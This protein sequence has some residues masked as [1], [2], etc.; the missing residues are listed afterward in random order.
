[1][2]HLRNIYKKSILISL[3]I[4]LIVMS[5]DVYAVEYNDRIF[6]KK[7]LRSKRL[8]AFS[9]WLEM[10]DRYK[11]ELRKE[12]KSFKCIV[13]KGNSDDIA[14]VSIENA[15]SDSED[16]R[17]ILKVTN[18]SQIDSKHNDHYVCNKSLWMK[19]K[20]LPKNSTILDKL[21]LINKIVNEEKYIIDPINWNMAD[22]W[23]TPNQFS[24]KDGDCEDYAISKYM[25]LKNIGFPKESMRVVILNDENLEI[26]H[27]VLAVYTEDGKIYILDNQISSVL[28]DREIH[29]YRPIYSINELYWWK[30][31]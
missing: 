14:T 29:H 25:I 6:G 12:S 13:P 10:L 3:I 9:K 18:N 17:K 26:L 20:L 21:K 31:K 8:K 1:M 7:E 4:L 5:N 19:I 28:E 2:L 22:Y 15:N 27:A 30:H 24:I 23:A 16:F 11:E